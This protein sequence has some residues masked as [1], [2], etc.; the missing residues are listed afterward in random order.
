M[1]DANEQVLLVDRADRV[2]GVE[3]KLEAHR[4]GAL[5]RAISVFAFNA[6]GD[7]LLQRRAAGKYHSPDLWANTCCSHP[8][9][10]EQT[11][12]AVMR[13]MGEE[14]N[15]DIP[16]QYKTKLIYQADVGNGLREH[17]LVHAFVGQIN[18]QPSPNPSEVS[19]TRFVSL[20]IIEKEMRQN[21]Q[22]F[23]AWFRVYMTVHRHELDAMARGVVKKS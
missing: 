4:T 21:R 18:E 11:M 16:L 23:A 8:R 12:N 17:E 20:P 3:G 13:R 10:G 6:C 9:P 1:I 19:E 22:Q 7:L 2:I 15:V 14:L 5:H